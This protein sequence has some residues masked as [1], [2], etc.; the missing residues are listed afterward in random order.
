MVLAEGDGSKLGITQPVWCGI[1]QP[2]GG[3]GVG[4]AL[5]LPPAG[6]GSARYVVERDCTL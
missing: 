5:P 1:R 2:D 4:A 6:A 3:G